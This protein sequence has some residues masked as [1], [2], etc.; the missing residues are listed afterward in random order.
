MVDSNARRS[1][2][3]HSVVR[4]APTLGT[5]GR[6]GSAAFV[7]WASWLGLVGAAGVTGCEYTDVVALRDDGVGDPVR[8]VDAAVSRETLSSAGN[9]GSADAA[10]TSD[11]TATTDAALGAACDGVYCF[12]FE[13]P[14]VPTENV[15]WVEQNGAL[16]QDCT[17]ARSGACSGAATLTAGGGVAYLAMDVSPA[18]VHWFVRAYVWI[19]SELVVDDIAII[20][21]GTRG[22]NA[23]VNVDLHDADR[24]E[25]FAIESEQAMLTSAGATRREEWMCLLVEVWTSD[26]AGQT[27]L[28]VDGQTVL[29]ASDVDTSPPNGTEFITVGIDWSSGN[30]QAGTLWFDDVVVSN[31]RVDCE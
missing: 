7:G 24:L 22:G 5:F 26:A 8:V 14:A 21:V 13:Q 4:T 27:S 1:V 18:Q 16:T 3:G 9:S 2:V 31:E 11:V 25:L 19:P 28:S 10:A 23:G 17:R 20:H 12:G 29:Q 15:E 30:Q 6:V